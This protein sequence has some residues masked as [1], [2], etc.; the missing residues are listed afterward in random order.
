MPNKKHI[1]IVKKRLWASGYKAAER[2][3]VGDECDLLI[4]G[5]RKVFVCKEGG[6]NRQEYAG[7]LVACVSTAHSRTSV[8]YMLPNGVYSISLR[9]VFGLP[10]RL[11]KDN[12]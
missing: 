6:Q 5:I 3:R 9:T 4:D 12:H 2:S 8:R 1:G 7:F 10:A 11:S